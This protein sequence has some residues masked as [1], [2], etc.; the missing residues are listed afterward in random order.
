MRYTIGNK[1]VADIHQ[2]KLLIN[3]TSPSEA[4]ANP[5]NFIYFTFA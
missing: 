1:T 5:K 4:P 3:A 2:Q